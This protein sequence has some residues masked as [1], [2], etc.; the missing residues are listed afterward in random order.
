MA[1]LVSDRP[2]PTAAG[3]SATLADWRAR[4]TLPAALWSDPSDRN[5]VRALVEESDDLTGAVQRFAEALA[6][7]GGTLAECCAHLAALEEIVSFPGS[8][9]ELAPLVADVF[10]G[11]PREQGV[12]PLTGLMTGPSLHAVLQARQQRAASAQGNEALELLAVVTERGMDSADV[13]DAE[14]GTAEVLVTTLDKAEAIGHLGAGR[15]VA[16]VESDHA[17]ARC[18][19]LEAALATRGISASL[20]R[21]ALAATLEAAQT[22]L[23][24][25]VTP[26]AE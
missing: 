21:E 4:S 23:D 20:R 9:W 2:L 6:D 13:L 11:A 1:L 22:Q 12:D 19:A 15:F 26:K 25:L 24:D 16:I 8:A 7:A 14:L 17:D 10:Y 3:V 5:L 18:G